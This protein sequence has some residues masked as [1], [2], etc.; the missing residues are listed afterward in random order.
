MKRILSLILALAMAL[1]CAFALTSCQDDTPELDLEYATEN[2]EK[3]GYTVRLIRGQSELK[4]YDFIGCVKAICVNNDSKALSNVFNSPVY[5]YCLVVAEFES[6]ETAELYV[7]KYSLMVEQDRI[8][9]ENEIDY[10]ENLLDKY[11]KYLDSDELEEY[12]E[13]IKE[14]KRALLELDD[15]V[16]GRSGSTAWFGS[17]T[18]VELSRGI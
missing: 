16:V 12:N 4:S 14:G 17:R 7:E 18:A 5:R 9:A 1:S 10:Y 11:K 3:A 6:S 15:I 8:E 2:L 13:V